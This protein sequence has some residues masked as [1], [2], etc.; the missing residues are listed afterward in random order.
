MQSSCSPR[1]RLVYFIWLAFVICA[2]LAS[3]SRILSLP[4]F[5]AK[6]AGDALWAMM[7]FVGF[8]LLFPK[9]RTTSIALMALAFSVAIETSQLYHAPWID[10]F[11]R[12]TLGKLALGDTFAWRDIAAYLVGI[13]VASAI[14]W[15]A[16]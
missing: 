2:G 1:S 14:E 8:G 7:V 5:L 16:L 13:F 4:P 11:R 3:R 12:T 6:Y 10:S 9:H 15:F